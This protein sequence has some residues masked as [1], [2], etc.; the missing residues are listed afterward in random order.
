[1][2]DLKGPPNAFLYMKV[3][4]HAGEGFEEILKRKRKEREEAG[5]TFW[6]YGGSVCHP[7]N[8]VQ[9]F[10]RLYAKEEGKIILLMEPMDSRANPVINP[11]KQYSVNNTDWLPI[12]KGVGVLGSKYALVLGDIVP[13]DFDVHLHE[14]TVGCGPNEGR[15][16]S[17]YLKFQIDKGC[18]VRAKKTPKS[19]PVVTKRVKFAAELVAPYAVLLRSGATNDL[20]KSRR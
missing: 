15:I 8:Q 3:G 20:T 11:A 10:A 6:G 16:A 1:M 12:P 14:F 13:V 17:D 5:L 2:N 7:L 4:V 19:A 18:F 9:P